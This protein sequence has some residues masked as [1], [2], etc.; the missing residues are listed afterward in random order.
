M[1]ESA[2]AQARETSGLTH[3]LEIETE[4]GILTTSF[5]EKL[6]SQIDREH[7]VRERERVSDSERDNERERSRAS[8]RD[9]ETSRFTHSLEIENERDR[10]HCVQEWER[11]SDRER[12][13][14]REPLA[15]K[16]ESHRDSVTL[17]TRSLRSHDQ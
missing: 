14:E 15:R 1:R 16:Q 2:R 9:I 8:K 5:R 3:S 7:C 17:F 4:I 10:E 13:N 12:D 6:H 11:V